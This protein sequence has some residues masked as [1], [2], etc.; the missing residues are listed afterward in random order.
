MLNLLFLI[1]FALLCLA[2]VAAWR[3]VHL[4]AKNGEPVVPQRQPV[5]SVLG[6]FD[7]GIMFATWLL[8]QFFALVWSRGLSNLAATEFKGEEL[9][10]LI[11]ISAICQLISTAVGLIILLA[12]H[13]SLRQIGVRFDHWQADLSLGAKSFLLAVP[14]LLILQ[15]LLSKIVT[16]E[17]ATL[18]AFQDHPT[19]FMLTAVWLAAVVVAPLCEEV[20]FRG[21]LQTWFQRWRRNGVTMDDL[22]LGG[23]QT[24]GVSASNEIPATESRSWETTSS[25]VGQMETLHPNANPYAS[26]QSISQ[27]ASDVLP[28]HSI[29]PNLEYSV[30]HIVLSA[31]IFAGVHIGQG[32]APIPLFLM[33]L[34]LGYLYFKTR[35]LLPCIVLHA[36]L[37]GFSMFWFTIGVLTQDISDLSRGLE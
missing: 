34:V 16:Y 2:S 17:H 25:G 33:G 5:R 4:Q 29:Q 23:N 35:S 3:R 8:G 12:R 26:P 6:L 21:I 20:F 1:I 9:A 18:N 36:G 28:Q 22:I 24:I 32:L 13:G 31:L 7:V 37:N 27:Q 30:L 19:A 10:Q 11:A 14:P 15:W